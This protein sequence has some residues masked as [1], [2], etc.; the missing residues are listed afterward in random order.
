MKIKYRDFEIDVWKA[1]GTYG[2]IQC[3]AIRDSDGFC[4]AEETVENTADTI[5]TYIEIMKGRVDDYYEH[6]EDYVPVKE[7]DD[8]EAKK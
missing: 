1:P 5:K 4:V 2:A 3:S 7:A 8:A 6:P